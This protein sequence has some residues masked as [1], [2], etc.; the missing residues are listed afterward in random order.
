MKKLKVLIVVPVVGWEKN[1][2]GMKKG[3]H[4]QGMDNY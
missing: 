4:K 1:T 3:R 2:S